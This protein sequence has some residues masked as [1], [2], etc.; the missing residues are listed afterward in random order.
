[1]KNLRNLRD[2]KYEQMKKILLILLLLPYSLYSQD[3]T[4]YYPNYLFLQTSFDIVDNQNIKM[5][6][7]IY[8]GLGGGL[9]LG[10]FRDGKKFRQ[11]VNI[12]NHLGL[13]FNLESNLSSNQQ[14]TYAGDLS[15]RIL[16]K[17][18]L[19]LLRNE[20]LMGAQWHLQVYAYSNQSLGNSGLT[21]DVFSG[22]D[23]SFSNSRSFRLFKHNFDW[24]Q[25]ISLG[26]ISFYLK[27]AYNYPAPEGYIMVSGGIVK[28]IYES[29]YAKSLLGLARWEIKES[30]YRTMHNGNR[31]ALSYQWQYYKLKTDKPRMAVIHS[32]GLSLY[33]NL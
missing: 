5:S 9:E 31:L 10:Y 19:S 32:L 6:P 7:A 20:I 26:L 22:L 33:F 23:Y 17:N 24:Q 11:T 29:F 27:E 3:S 12:A 13:A 2:K 28:K 30:L 18:H 1:M 16:K 21:D 14:L 8:S 25:D 4:K 15:Y